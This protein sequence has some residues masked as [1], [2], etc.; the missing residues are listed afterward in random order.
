M[1]PVRTA[2][3]GVGNFGSKHAAKHAALAGIDLV[4]VVD[5]EADRAAAVAADLGVR[6][7]TDHRR[8]V[9]L[10]DAVSIVVPTA[11][12]Y[13]VA[14]FFLDNGIHVL[15]EKPIARTLAEADDLI[16]RARTGGLVLQVGHLE[17][18]FARE[19]GLEAAVRLPLYFESQRIAPFRLRGSDVSVVLDLM[20]HDIDLIASLV[21]QPVTQVDAVGAPVLSAEP[22]IVNTRLKFANGCVASLV[23]SRVADKS[24]RRLR[25]FQPD[26]L[27]SVDLLERHVATVRKLPNA[28]PPQALANGT[29]AFS[30]DHQKYAEGDPLQAEIAA[31]A[32]A[33]ATG[34]EPV[35]TG[36]DGRRALETALR[37]SASLE[38]HLELVRTLLPG[39]EERRS[40]GPPGA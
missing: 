34:G 6:A 21:R 16:A 10:V 15:V 4:A 28:G 12:H 22:D 30:V 39:H 19:I 35:V 24:E 40:E 1:K 37:I 2:V 38:A 5:I 23:A 17:R 9:G 13:G 25:I 36:E 20:I 29:G 14:R 8:L 27:I 31:F 33:V 11:D 3:V 7:F 18:F 26:C 32:Q